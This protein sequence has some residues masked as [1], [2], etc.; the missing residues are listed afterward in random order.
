MDNNKTIEKN[1]VCEDFQSQVSQFLVRH[2]S[3][4]DIMSK[5]HEYNSRINRAVVKSVTNCGCISINA[6]KQEFSGESYC[7][8]ANKL[9]NHIRGKLCPSCKEI[10][11]S[12][13]GNYLFYLASLC[14]S[15]DLD[16]MDILSK[17]S[18]KNN[19]LGIYSLR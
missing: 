19:T 11:D 4:L 14:N 9:D 13:I 2:K 3:V 10:I 7:D 6:S 12:E 17:E 5:M 15:L 16:L 1:I 18:D 8:L